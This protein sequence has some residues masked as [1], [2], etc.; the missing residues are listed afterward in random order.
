MLSGSIQ[1]GVL[2][3]AHHGRGSDAVAIQNAASHPDAIASAAVAKAST[4]DA[5]KNA[6]AHSDSLAAQ[7]HAGDLFAG[8]LNNVLS[9][10]AITAAEL[11]TQNIAEQ[12]RLDQKSAEQA[13]GQLG[14]EVQHPDQQMLALQPSAEEWLQAML[15]QQQLQLQARDT[16]A[17]DNSV[18]VAEFAAVQS[19][20]L[21]ASATGDMR[22]SESS[23]AVS[24]AAAALVTT[25]APLSATQTN[26]SAAVDISARENSVA[27][28]LTQEKLFADKQV[29]LASSTTELNAVAKANLNP[30]AAAIIADTR[31]TNDVRATDA[32]SN[33]VQ[34]NTSSSAIAQLTAAA[35]NE[36]A[37]GD[38]TTP[39]AAPSTHVAGVESAQRSVQTPVNLHAPEAKWGE[40][41]LHTLR[42]KVQVQIQQ[43]I[44]NA[45]I[46][47][48]PPELGSLEIYL[49]HEAG[50]LQVHITAS[51]ADVARL[52][53]QTSDR[54][55]QELSSPQF[56]Q[57]NIQTSAEGQAGQQQSRE[58][59]RFISDEIVLA[60]EQVF[61]GNDT[62]TKRTSDVLVTV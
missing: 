54:L 38:L 46:R 9:D 55:R 1:S 57:V 19:A 49:S 50:R 29:N 4:S 52:I 32:A 5:E 56:S 53:Q 39:A 15:D 48:D 2:S 17:S 21:G 13:N 30:L 25:Q 31:T 7:A 26:L 36:T 24:L 51:Q 20:G 12:N 60:N 43:N 14:V 8:Q 18:T 40:Q 41:L 16:A 33:A 28:A 62:S 35:I 61:V 3:Q 10:E 59:Q 58:R 34:A 23:A 47:L 42:D 37:A 27:G 45:T 11:L 22:A 44:Q 6:K